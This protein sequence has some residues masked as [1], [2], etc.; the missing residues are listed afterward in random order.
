[1][2]TLLE[3]NVFCQANN[4]NAGAPGAAIRELRIQTHRIPNQP[5]QNP[6]L[7]SNPN[8]VAVLNVQHISEAQAATFKAGRNYKL[9]VVE[10]EAANQKSGTQ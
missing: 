9:L 6:G 7:F 8:G 5:E 2:K 3:I 4:E 10:E 1:M